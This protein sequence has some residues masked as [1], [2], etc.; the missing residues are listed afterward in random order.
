MIGNFFSI[1]MLHELKVHYASNNNNNSSCNSN[2]SSNSDKNSNNNKN[3]NL[4]EGKCL[5]VMIIVHK[6]NKTK[7]TL[8]L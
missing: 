1:V 6:K 2:D 4:F 3:M 7:K 8:Y 5:P